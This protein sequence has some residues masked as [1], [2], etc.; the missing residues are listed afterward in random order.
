M[1]SAITPELPDIFL[2]DYQS[3]V[4]CCC[5]GYN[6]LYFFHI[7]FLSWSQTYAHDYHTEN[8]YRTRQYH[9]FIGAVS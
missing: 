9:L 7:R 2:S 8:G 4:W 1:E 3:S 6:D 5:G